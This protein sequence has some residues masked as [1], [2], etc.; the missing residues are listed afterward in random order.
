MRTKVKPHVISKGHSWG[1]DWGLLYIELPC[2]GGW[3]IYR[4]SDGYIVTFFPYD[5]NT[6]GYDFSKYKAMRASMPPH[7]PAINA[8]HDMVS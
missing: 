6:H 7:D 1:L 4:R 2:L 8:A 3:A 5:K